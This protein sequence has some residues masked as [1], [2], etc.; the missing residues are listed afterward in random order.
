M[1]ANDGDAHGHRAPGRS[2]NWSSG[3]S[4]VRPTRR[5]GYTVPPILVEALTAGF[6][7]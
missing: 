2:A 5:I 4:D 6:G 3:S 7:I 1:V